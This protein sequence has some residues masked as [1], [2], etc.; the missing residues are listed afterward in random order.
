MTIAVLLAIAAQGQQPPGARPEFEVAAVKP[1]D[2]ADPSSSARS[3]PGGMEMRNTTLRTLVRSAY[4]LN[5]HQLEGGP[6]W[7]DSARFTIVAK[8]PAGASRDQI[9]LMLQS[10]LAERFRFES[11]RVTKELPLYSLVIAKGGPKLQAT[12]GDERYPG[13]S[14]QGD[15]MIRGRGLPVSSLAAMLIGPVGA[16]VVNRTKL[17]GLYTFNL[18]FAS[19][20]GTPREDETLPTVFVAL[21]E[22]LGL[23][24]EPGRGAI[25]ILVVDRADMPGEN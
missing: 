9:P 2:P 8:L 13:S 16:P 17:A 15:R 19:L 7:M 11:H 10:L 4:G 22:R 1:G 18:D 6:K 14:S 12:A 21:Q 23:K 3:S 24:L 25:E 20:M 5:E